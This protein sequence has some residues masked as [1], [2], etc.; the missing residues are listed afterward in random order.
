MGG[1]S[2][3]TEYMMQAVNLYDS[4]K[5]KGIRPLLAGKVLD[6][7]PHELQLQYGEDKF[8]FIYRFGCIVSFNMTIEECDREISKVK[9]ALGPGIAQP[10][11]ETYNVRIHEGAPR[12]E[13]EYAEVKKLT[14]DY[15]RLA[16]VTLGQ[17]AALEYFEINTES[18]LHDT[19]LFM[20]NLAKTGRVPFRARRFMKFI[21][22]AASARQNIISNLSILD[23]PE[24]TWA[25]KELRK[26][27]LELQQN[28][29]IDVRFRILD[30]KLT[31]IQDNIEILARLTASRTTTIL[32]VM[33][34][35]LIL[36]EIAFAVLSKVH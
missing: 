4:I 34:V 8:I 13:S 6:S 26:L 23:P 27:H 12:V 19:A 5:L 16:A 29:D 33:V 11:T 2:K 36:A 17:S 1:T 32:E 31:L 30:R 10:T 3:V 21:G 25:S 20:Q 35:L 15:L 22:S 14:L 18:M 7:S 28:F 24:E 9:S